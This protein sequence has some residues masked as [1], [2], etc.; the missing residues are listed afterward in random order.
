[1]N[2]TFIKNEVNTR[3]TFHIFNNRNLEIR[4]YIYIKDFAW[5][6]HSDHTPT[7]L[8]YSIK[9]NTM[10]FCHPYNKRHTDNA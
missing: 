4:K 8:Q 5:V 2:Y 3:Y 1:M 10:R 7:W 6:G 9:K